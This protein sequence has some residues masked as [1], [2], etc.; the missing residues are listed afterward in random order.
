MST[1]GTVVDLLSEVP[2]AIGLVKR[3]IE[4]V[5]KARPEDRAAVVAAMEQAADSTLSAVERATARLAAARADE[6]T[7]AFARA[8]LTGGGHE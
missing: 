2:E 3:I 6:P 1:L 5:R 8:G 4:R 7:V